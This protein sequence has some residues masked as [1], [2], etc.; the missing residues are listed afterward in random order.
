MP[1]IKNAPG[2]GSITPD[3]TFTDI[4]AYLDIQHAGYGTRFLSWV[5]K[6]NTVKA[7]FN[8]DSD[9]FGSGPD[10]RA[11][12]WLAAWLLFGDI[13]PNIGKTIAGGIEKSGTAI[14][15]QIL[16]GFAKG[17]GESPGASA[18]A[19]AG[20]L[21][22][23]A[24]ITGF[25]QS[26]TARSLWVRIAEGIIGGALIIIAVSKLAGDTSVG[27]AATKAGKVVR[28]L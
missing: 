15:T 28:L 12:N 4:A 22:S 17:V 8:P 26:L 23:G 9:T 18:L 11:I 21:V 1:V 14:T 20:N 25:L 19:G 6:H 24:G 5:Q 13:G 7:P 10:T 3:S 16:P 27:R 2:Q